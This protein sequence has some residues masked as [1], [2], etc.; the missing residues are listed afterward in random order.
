MPSS[1]PVRSRSSKLRLAACAAAVL[2]MAGAAVM[3][4]SCSSGEPR[5]AMRPADRIEQSK[6]Y[7]T[8]QRSAEEVD[9]PAPGFSAKVGGA[10]SRAEIDAKS[11]RR[12]AAVDPSARAAMA[13]GRTDPAR[14]RLIQPE[15]PAR[16]DY[17][18]TCRDEL[19]VIERRHADLCEPQ[20]N[21]D[22][23]GCGSLVTYAPNTTDQVPVPLKHTDVAAS[24]SAYISSVHVTQTFA[25]P[26]DSKI[27][28]VYVFPLPENSAV[29]DFVMKVGDRT[30]RGIIRDRDD[31][32]RI[33]T[34]AR[35]QGYV[36]SLLT[37]ERPNIFTQRIAN[38]E[39]GRAIDVDITYYSTLTF[40]DG[41]YEFVFPMVVGPRF[42]P[43]GT[44]NG[45]GAADRRAP[46]STGQPTEVTYLRP[47]ERSGSDISLAVDIDAGVAI[48]DIESPTHTIQT[49]RPSRNQARVSLSRHDSIPNRD[50]VLRYRISGDVV[51]TALMTHDDNRGGFFT[52][53][54]VPPRSLASQS[55][56]P[57][58]MVY[59]LDCSGSMSGRPIEQAKL[60]IERSLSKLDSSDTFQIID[61]AQNASTLGG[62]P[63]IANSRNLREG[64]NYLSSLRANGGTYM[65]TGMRAALDFP[66]DPERLRVV[67]FLTDG[68]IGNEP[69]ILRELDA[70]LEDS[71]VFGFGV[72]QAPNRHLMDEMSRMGRGAVAYVGLNE[73]P[74]LAMEQFMDRATKP[75]L[76][77]LR[78][79]WGGARVSEVYPRRIPDLFVGRP[80]IITGRYEG[81]FTRPIRVT[82][83]ADGSPKELTIRT[84]S[85]TPTQAR[86]AIP[87]VW[88]RT[89]IAD[90]SR[91]S[92]MSP[93]GADPR[94]Q[95]ELRQTALNYNLLSDF[96][97]FVAVDSMT[98][99]GG[100]YGTTV[101]VPV[102]VPE[103][104]RYDTTVRGSSHD[105]E[106]RE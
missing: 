1:R 64:R 99:T 69:E 81:A 23:P 9:S 27:E 52:L 41:S 78:I 83:R 91:R 56:Q 88:A 77:N 86:A 57:V 19:W 98:R 10:Y 55:R 25:N 43:P 68:F 40:S 74:N 63:L 76:T 59:V 79:D 82:G 24:I 84:E 102:P 95:S 20:P 38:I 12:L 58:E 22:A 93:E 48:E 44:S 16:S 87:Q 5:S 65:V 97:S 71:R 42:N 73:D 50:F 3:I 32:Q 7:S 85:T 100:S 62:S 54:L 92:L 21:D 46:G 8:Y 34:Q 29:S 70:R 96:T 61:F 106:R 60:A 31:A 26:F 51:K 18:T 37:Q 39:P 28:A 90:L 14:A 49:D 47:R 15:V 72:G 101:A 30:I 80:V 35:A 66:H 94:A 2:A 36:A 13:G 75:A 104:T 103:G 4:Q 11:P 89:K 67:A 6:E 33:Y 45:V 17:T 53:M 105:R